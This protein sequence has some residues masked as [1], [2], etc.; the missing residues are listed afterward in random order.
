[1]LRP[2]GISL[3]FA[4]ALAAAPSHADGLRTEPDFRAS[5]EQLVEQGLSFEEGL[6]LRFQRVFDPQSLPPAL[7]DPDPWPAKSAT[8]LVQELDEMREGISP[9]LVDLMDGYLRHAPLSPL[10]FETEHFRL[11]YETAGAHAVDPEDVAPAN[12]VPDFVDRVG[13]YAELAWQRLFDKT[14]FTP[15]ALAGDRY[16]ILFREM[17]AY[18][19]TVP[20][21]GTTRIVLHRSF[22]GFPA[23]DDPE[24]PVP[25]AAKVSTAHELKHASQYSTSGWT[26]GGWLEAD[27]TWAEELVFD[28][29]NDYLR[30]LPFG[31][32]VSHPDS[33]LE[34]GV[35]SYEDCLWQLLLAETYGDEILVDFFR[36]RADH[37]GEPVMRSF[38]HVLTSL[39]G[40]LERSAKTL[41]LW[42]YLAGANSA[43]APVGFE[44]GASFPT[45]PLKASI[46]GLDDP[47]TSQVPGLGSHYVHVIPP[48]GGSR[49]FVSFVGDRGSSFV[50][51]AIWLNPGGHRTV[52][53]IPSS[54]TDAVHEVPVDWSQAVILVLAITSLDAAGAESGYYVNVNEGTPV[55]VD[56]TLSTGVFSLEPNRP[57][58][59]R[60]RTEITFHLP[61]SSP[62]RLSV[63]DVAGR[64]VRRLIEGERRSPGAHHVT[65]NGA[66]ESG[67]LAAPGVYYYRLEATGRSAT[68]KMLLLR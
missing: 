11:L 67:R 29:T 66:D 17:S 41:G 68:R 52:H 21:D 9:A 35:A 38:D 14:G 25:G 45:P 15:P 16:E 43:G 13:D 53:E 51:R 37:P 57:N 19:Y 33:W 62:V 42:S 36:R 32:P 30:Y 23:N 61:Q 39:G 56:P 28:D 44:E 46:S 22:E 26:E 7:R 12:G 10:T 65:W 64:L 59:F 24:G 58:P 47:R 27:A 5:V 60:S 20:A 2:L 63:H 50:V 4:V 54:A 6:L 49:P 31:S 18:G 1:M 34:N 8:R 55:G 48:E 40:S 3:I